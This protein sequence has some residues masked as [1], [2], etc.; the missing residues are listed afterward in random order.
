MSSP[1]KEF[2][3]KDKKLVDCKVVAFDHHCGYRKNGKCTI[4]QTKFKELGC[5]YKED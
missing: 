3:K 5:P 1:K 2:L 4:D